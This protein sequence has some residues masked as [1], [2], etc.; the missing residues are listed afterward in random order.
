M[1]KKTPLH[2]QHLEA[3]GKMVPFAGYELPVQYPTGVIAEHMA[4]RQK[5]GLFDVSHMGEVLFTGPDALQNL[6]Y[7]LTNDFSN[8]AD[9]QVRYTVMCNET[10]GIVDDLLVYK[11]HSEKYMLVINAANREKDVAWM[12]KHLFGACELA[13][14]SDDLAQIALQGPKAQAILEKVA[15][16]A[17]IPQKY[18]HFTPKADVG[19]ISCILSTTG[20]TG[21]SGFELYMNS[22]DAPA[23]WKLLLEAGAEF[24]LIPCGLG[25]RDTLRLEAG[26]PLYGH[27][28]SM[29]ITP[30]EAALDF[31]VKM[32][33]D[34]F[35]GKQA[36]VEKGK[37][38]KIRV[39]L[40]VV[41]RGIIR[42]DAPLFIG[43]KQVGF[44]TSGTHCP[45]LEKAAA[46]ALVDTDY[47]EEGTLFQAEVRG[48]RIEAKVIP[49]PFYKRG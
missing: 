38:Q 1:E 31:C 42:E 11:F 33:K 21:E 37:P 22:A 2:S 13:D 16:T 32:K 9:G 26:M 7:L 27:E 12:K 10:G 15:S 39:G 28:T 29:E 41:G 43:E 40:E 24:G 4:V 5:A 44:T 3:N 14:I 49:L 17:D 8:M 36:L 45:Y 25:A 18:Y 34:D 20:Y 19:G 48:R 6:N 47:A 30:F 35:V 46:M 23:L